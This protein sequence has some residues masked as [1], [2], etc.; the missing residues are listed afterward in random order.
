MFRYPKCYDVIVSETVN[1]F[2]MALI[3]VAAGV[4]LGWLD[5]SQA[6]FKA[7]AW[8]KS[9]AAVICL[10]FATL[11]IGSWF[12]RG[13]GIAWN[14]Y[15]EEIMQQAKQ[16]Q[17]TVVIDFYATWCAPCRELEEITFHTPSVVEEAEA[18]FIMIKVDVT[19]GDNPLHQQLLQQYEVKGVPTIVF[20]D[21]NGVEKRALRLVDYLPAD[22]FLSRMR[23]LQKTD[24]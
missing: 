13:Q 16:R 19:K 23:Q 22:Q 5:R 6:D 10:V 3:V 21:R 20:I 8:A 15:S 1:V 7:F 24:N 4:H 9:G 11:L 12:L 2:M 18:N 17:K 14:A